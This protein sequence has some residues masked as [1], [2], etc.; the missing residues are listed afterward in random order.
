MFGK[1]KNQIRANATLSILCRVIKS[2]QPN[3]GGIRARKTFHPIQEILF[4]SIIIAQITLLSFLFTFSIVYILYRILENSLLISN[5]A[6]P[7]QGGTNEKNSQNPQSK[8][9]LRYC[10]RPLPTISLTTKDARKS[11]KSCSGMASGR[12]I[13]YLSVF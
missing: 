7:P 3:M 5:V 10:L 8:Y 1:K 12:S 11:T 9:L 2:N 13:R 4:R 6:I